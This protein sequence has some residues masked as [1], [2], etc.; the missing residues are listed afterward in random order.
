M[1]ADHDRAIRRVDPH[2]RVIGGLEIGL[3]LDGEH[4]H[5]HAFAAEFLDRPR[6]IVG[7]GGIM[8]GLELAL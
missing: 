2:A 7:E 3:V 4:L 1:A 8:F 6:E 5:R